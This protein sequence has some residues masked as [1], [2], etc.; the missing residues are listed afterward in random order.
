LRK[1]L[2]KEIE[3]QTAVI[4]E[5]QHKLVVAKAYLEAQHDMLKLLPK[6]NGSGKVPVLR[7]GS[8]PARIR[9]ILREAGRPMHIS[10][11]LRKLGRETTRESRS[12]LSGTLGWYVNRGAIFS[13]PAPNTF[14][15]LEGAVGGV[16]ETKPP[17]DFGT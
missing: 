15:S 14:A 10:D 3:K 11:I 2:E 4:G 6:T 5:L 13:H 17:D 12:A 9:D 8:D 7:P 16:E 1:K